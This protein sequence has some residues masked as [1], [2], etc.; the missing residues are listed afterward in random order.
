MAVRVLIE[1]KDQLY[2]ANGQFGVLEK[3]FLD[4]VRPKWLL[5]KDVHPCFEASLVK[6]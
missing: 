2:F 5:K 1:T 6:A 3:H 4:H